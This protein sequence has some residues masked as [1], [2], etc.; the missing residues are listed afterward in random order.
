VG[1]NCVDLILVRPSDELHPK[2]AEYVLNSDYA[3][4]RVDEFSV[5]T[6]QSHFNV[7]ALK[8]MPIPILSL[9]EQV[10]CVNELDKEIG[11]IDSLLH[12]LS[13]QESLLAERRRALITAAVTGHLDVA[14]SRGAEAA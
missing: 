1:A 10:R 2:Y 9:T 14:T 12:Q 13:N 4:A 6:I 7:A 3:R 5:G 11:T 8:Q